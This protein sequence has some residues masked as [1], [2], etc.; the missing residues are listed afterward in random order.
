[1]NKD[2]ENFA[3]TE[4]ENNLM[5]LPLSFK[6]VFLKMYLSN[7]KARQ[8]ITPEAITDD[9]IHNCIINMP[10]DK[11]DWALTQVQNSL[12]NLNNKK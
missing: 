11:L 10:S 12:I 6:L 2:I 3:R 9:I 5:K 8:D 7:D 1:M 4:I